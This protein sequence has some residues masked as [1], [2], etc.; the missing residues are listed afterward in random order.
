[1]IST[2]VLNPIIVFPVL[3]VAD[4]CGDTLFYSFG[5]FGRNRFIERWGHYIGITPSRIE[6]LEKHFHAHCGKTI[7]IAKMIN[8]AAVAMLIAAGIA[9][10][11]YL[12][13]IWFNLIATIPKTLT[14][15]LIGF[16]FGHAYKTLN[17]Y[18]DSA[19]L[20][21]LILILLG[22]LLYFLLK[23]FKKKEIKVLSKIE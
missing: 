5:R 6:R 19:G 16:F 10:L 9:K 23:R 11:S 1:L 8:F 13:F 4:L 21:F 14:L 12:K 17:T 20:V 7:I 3:I 2:K 18:I 22:S 15:I